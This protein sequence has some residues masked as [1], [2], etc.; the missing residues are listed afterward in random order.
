M[1]GPFFSFSLVGCAL[2]LS[3]VALNA[4]AADGRVIFS[5]AIVE[6]TCHVD[7]RNLDMASAVPAPSRVA[8]A[9]ASGVTSVAPQAYTLNITHLSTETPDRLLRYFAGYVKEGGAD[10]AAARLVTQTYD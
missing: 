1:T 10:I 8:C 5:G 9:G 2:A 3:L 6:P 7:Q 4:R